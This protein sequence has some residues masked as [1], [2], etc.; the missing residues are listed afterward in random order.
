[1]RNEFEEKIAEHALPWIV[2]HFGNSSYLISENGGRIEIVTHGEIALQKMAEYICTAGNCAAR[3]CS[4]LKTTHAIFENLTK[5][6]AVKCKMCVEQPD[7]TMSEPIDVMATMPGEIEEVMADFFNGLPS[8]P[9]D[10]E[11]ERR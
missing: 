6:G 1:M 2:Q 4:L 7:G 8:E 3:M 9:Q 11:G 10:E 5:S